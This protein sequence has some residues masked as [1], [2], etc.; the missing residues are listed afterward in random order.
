M[1]D[2][3]VASDGHSYE[4]AAIADVLAGPNKKS[5]LTREVLRPELV[6]NRA[7]RRRIEEHEKELDTLAEQLEAR[8]AQVTNE[9]AKAAAE[10][11][12]EAARAEGRAE[13]EALRRQL[14]ECK[15]A[16]AE[17]GKRSASEAFED[18]D[19]RRTRPRI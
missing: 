10:A 9:T 14:D 6:P 13:A 2:P 17:A 12:A 15:A 4:R 7:L 11:A 16:L 19:E 3:V 1:N 5:P 18:S 8:M